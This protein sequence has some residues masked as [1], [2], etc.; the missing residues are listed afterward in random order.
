MA[1][2][3]D[4]DEDGLT[5]KEKG[6]VLRLHVLG[7]LLGSS[8]VIGSNLPGTLTLTLQTSIGHLVDHEVTLGVD[9]HGHT[10]HLK[11]NGI[12]KLG[13]EIFKLSNDYFIRADVTL[14]GI[15]IDIKARAESCVSD[16]IFHEL[17]FRVHKNG[18]AIDLQ[19]NSIREM[20]VVELSDDNFIGT[21]IANSG[22]SIDVEA[23]AE[24]CV[25]D[26]IGH[27]LTLGINKHGNT[28]NLQGDC[29]AG[30][31]ALLSLNDSN[32]IRANK[33]DSAVTVDIF[34][35]VESGISDF[36]GQK[37]T[38]GIDKDWNAIELEKIIAIDTLEDPVTHAKISFRNLILH[39]NRVDENGNTLSIELQVA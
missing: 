6:L 22:V 19:S 39:Q 35:G 8:D 29:I 26:L 25:S 28:I 2:L 38:F 16:I 11:D 31:Y 14:S 17:T 7:I 5:V 27:E 4:V 37:F 33:A 20:D 23:R 30:R 12:V 10:V 13:R 32:I 3:I 21:D 15:S 24:S 18:D 34:A 1:N 9:E 36:I